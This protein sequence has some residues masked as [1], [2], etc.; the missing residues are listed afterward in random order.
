MPKSQLRTKARKLDRASIGLTTAGAGV[1]GISGIN[2]AAIQRAEAKKEMRGISKREQ[3]IFTPGPANPNDWRDYSPNPQPKKQNIA[4]KLVAVKSGGIDPETRRQRGMRYRQN[5]A[6]AAA[7]GIGATAVVPHTKN[8]KDAKAWTKETVKHAK[9]AK[10]L[11]AQKAAFESYQGNVPSRS[12]GMYKIR[13]NELGSQQK[14]HK[15]AVKI[16]AKNAAKNIKI[17]PK[18]AA[19]SGIAGAT[20]IGI[21]AMRRRQGRA[22]TDW[23]DV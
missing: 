3:K 7:I 5:A 18:L 23:W 11:K 16:S 4:R 1:G 17:R 12:R 19:V 13:L 9:K 6:T 8:V 20:A 15:T 14:A 10:Q 22:Y 2:F 21:G